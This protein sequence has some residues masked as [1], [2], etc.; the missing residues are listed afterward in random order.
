MLKATILKQTAPNN[1]MY[2]IGA[3]MNKKQINSSKA[4]A[5]K[6]TDNAAS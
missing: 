5:A 4:H 3:G 2:A 1:A 6:N